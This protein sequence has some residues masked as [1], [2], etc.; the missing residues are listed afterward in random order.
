MK[1]NS[2][3]DELTDFESFE[4]EVPTFC[5]VTGD[6]RYVMLCNVSH[7]YDSHHQE[8]KL[9]HQYDSH[10][11]GMIAMIPTSLSLTAGNP[12]LHVSLRQSTHDL[13]NA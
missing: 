12:H 7:Q 5:L 13:H 11:K 6:R 1:M 9:S 4:L 10:L 8:N 2:N 3:F